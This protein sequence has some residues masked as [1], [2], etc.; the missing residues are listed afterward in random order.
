VQ[1]RATRAKELIFVGDGAEWIW[2]LVEFYYPHAVQ[3]VD[4]FHAAEHLT[5]VS[6]LSGSSAEEHSTW[7]RQRVTIVA[8]S[9]GSSHCG[10]QHVA[11][12]GT[13]MTRRRSR[14]LFYQQSP[15]H[16]LSDLPC[17]RVSDC[18]GTIES[19][20]KQIGTQRLKVPGAPGT[21]KARRVAKARAA[22]LSRQWK[23]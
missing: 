15:P 7:R 16:G 3:I 10:M 20:C 4:W 23:W 14:Y 6:L 19:G 18:S 9:T 1:R 8:W 12:P 11:T 2:N 5:P 17:Q 21:N 13:K 22:Y